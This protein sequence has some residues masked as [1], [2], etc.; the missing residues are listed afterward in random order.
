MM[1]NP[2]VAPVSKGNVL[3]PGNLGG[4]LCVLSS[5]LFTRLTMRFQRH[6]RSTRRTGNIRRV[7]R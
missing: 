7:S 1:S 3:A 4:Q 6:R 5:L 2:F